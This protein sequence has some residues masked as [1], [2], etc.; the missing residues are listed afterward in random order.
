MPLLLLVVGGGGGGATA[1]VAAVVL[2]AAA[3]KDKLLLRFF[4]GICI[5][6]SGDV[7]SDLTVRCLEEDGA[8]REYIRWK[9]NRWFFLVQLLFEF[10]EFLQF[11]PHSH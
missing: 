2:I 6:R 10:Q 5:H 3:V 11:L 9:G 8:E 4:V 1:T 7:K